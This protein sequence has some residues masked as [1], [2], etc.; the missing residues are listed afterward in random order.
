MVTEPPPLGKEISDLRCEANAA[1]ARIHNSQELRLW[2]TTYLGRQG[3]VTGLLHRLG[4]L[5]P[6]QRPA[7]GREANALKRDLEA[8]Y[9]T[10]A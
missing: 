8:T 4:D 9:E 6:E 7:A 2:R 3:A 5:A 10:L 1:L